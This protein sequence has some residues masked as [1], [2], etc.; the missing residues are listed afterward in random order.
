[1]ERVKVVDIDLEDVQ[2]IDGLEEYAS[3]KGLVRMR[4]TP[5]G[6]VQLPVKSGRC[7]ER[8]IRAAIFKELNNPIVRRLL[9]DKLAEPDRV[10]VFRLVDLFDVHARAT[11]A[12]APLVTVAVCT[13][14]R[15]DDLRLCL[16]ALQRLTY[17]RLDILVVDN[18]P[19]SDA[20]E[21]L[22]RDEFPGIRYVCEPRP[23]LDWARNRA[24]VEARGE[25]IAYTDDD[26]IVDPSWVSA[27]VPLFNEPDVGAVTGLVVPYELETRAQVLFERY[28][29]FGRGFERR[30][31]RTGPGTDAPAPTYL[32]AGQFGTGANMAYRR[33]MF[34]R[35]GMFDT[36]L[37]VGTVTN[38]GGDL[39]MFF[40][41][42]KRGFTLVYEPCAIVRHRHRRDYE[43]LHTQLANNGIG[44]YSMWVKIWKQY[45]D[46]RGN[47][48]R[49]GLWWFWWWHIRR[50]LKSYVRP[51]FFPRDLIV[52]EMKGVFKG[53]VRYQQACRIAEQ[54]A[55]DTAKYGPVAK[56]PQ[57]YSE[58]A[59]S[60]G[61]ARAAVRT[62]ELSR[63][64]V[65][66]DDLDGYTAVRVFFTLDGDPVG[67]VLIENQNASVS[68]T[69][70]REALTLRHSYEILSAFDQTDPADAWFA[71]TVA[72][73]SAYGAG[74]D[75]ER[76]PSERLPE[77]VPVSIV[78]STYDRP[79]DLRRCLDMLTGQAFA[80]PVEIIVVD[81]HP[82]S[83]VT[84]P[85]VGD[86]PGVR[87]L[88]E[89]R[90]G[91]SYGRNRGFSASTGEILI[92]IDDD[93]VIGPH[94]LENLVA[95]FSRQDVMVVTGNVLPLEL[96]TSAQ[97]WF[98]V[99]GGLGK[100]Y[101]RKEA[102]REWFQRFR[103]KAVPTWELGAAA[104]MAFRADILADPAIGMMDETLGAGTPTGCSEDTYLFYKVLKA[105]HTIVYE[106]RAYVWHRHRQTMASLRKQIYNYSKGH[107]AYHLTTVVDDGDLRGLS[108]VLIRVPRWR[109]KSFKHQIA[110]ALKRR[111]RFPLQLVLIALAGD[112]AGPWAFWTSR[113]RVRR[114]GRS[115]P[116]VPVEN[117]MSSPRIVTRVESTER[118]IAS[119]GK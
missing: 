14:D 73:E 29:G 26:V 93:V 46:E 34:E 18:A 48:L 82:A 28:G 68:V 43:K 102:G 91:L 31:F 51:G 95:P 96:E 83:G 101:Q 111:E 35:I 24:I 114:L 78:I 67:D 55:A 97:R 3:L 30:W 45:P 42:L 19:T 105:D 75:E 41:T 50:Y 116:Y 80:R 53:F 40:R 92:T 103:R 77:Y 104:N 74:T 39:E 52:A 57:Q 23:G 59:R 47:L 5:V 90:G 12:Y 10:G 13:R 115:D 25:I 71:A 21:R 70:L 44:L 84:P 62:V 88:S 60:T 17:E 99:Y 76:E 94:W 58:I 65:P 6:W 38:G 4:G 100:G 110:S 72:L 2:S 89:P 106:P 9:V 66:I 37:D 119:V 16:A 107:V 7:S 79:D 32:G 117:R 1:M 22:V 54:I 8:S 85:V 63:P 118:A 69:R 113:Q 36:A 109:L 61:E 49:I 15:P 33:S 112:L 98:E 108:D 87:L 11:S 64:L 56:L 20:T 86:F 81:N 27:M